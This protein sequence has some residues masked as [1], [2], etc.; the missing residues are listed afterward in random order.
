MVRLYCSHRVVVRTRACDSVCRTSVLRNDGMIARS[1]LNYVRHVADRAQH[2]NMMWPDT[3]HYTD[4]APGLVH[5][6]L[7]DRGGHVDRG[8][9]RFARESEGTKGV[10]TK[11]GS[12]L[13]NFPL[14]NVS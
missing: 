5:S 7:D 12:A 8:C 4:R 3:V 1:V 13:V 2:I 11:G 14:I 10:L 9:W 6:N